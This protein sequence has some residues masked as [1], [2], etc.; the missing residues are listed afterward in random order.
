MFL[1]MQGRTALLAGG[2]AEAYG[3]ISECVKEVLALA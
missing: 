2:V 3:G 1:D